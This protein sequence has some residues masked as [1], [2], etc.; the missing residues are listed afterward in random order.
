L[1][2][3]VCLSVFLS[4]CLSV[5][6]FALII[7]TSSKFPQIIAG[8]KFDRDAAKAI[9]EN[10]DA[11]FNLCGMCKIGD[12]KWWNYGTEQGGRVFIEK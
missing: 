3:S 9:S 11:F 1:S 5:P 12:A 7:S 6:F 8:K 10:F 2:A 4:V